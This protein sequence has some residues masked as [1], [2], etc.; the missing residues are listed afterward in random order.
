MNPYDAVYHAVGQGCLVNPIAIRPSFGDH[1]AQWNDTTERMAHI[2]FSKILGL[3]QSR[4]NR[5]RTSCCPKR[6]VLILN[7]TGASTI[8]L[9]LLTLQIYNECVRAKVAGQPSFQ[10]DEELQSFFLSLG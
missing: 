1:D 7:A 4:E 9:E 10:T 6:I 2:G 8:T 5:E 3:P